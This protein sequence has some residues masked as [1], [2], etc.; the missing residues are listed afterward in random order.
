MLYF[1][2]FILLL[3]NVGFWS[4]TF[5]ALPGNWLIVIS[6]WGFELWRPETVF[7]TT[8][9]VFITVLA[10]IGELIEFIGGMGGAKKAGAGL[11]GTLGALLGAILGAILGTILLPI[12]FAGTFAGACIGAGIG[13]WCFELTREDI[14]PGHAVKMGVGAGIGVLIGTGSKI[15][16]GAL[17]CVIIAF[18]AFV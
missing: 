13:T 6:A 12:P 14:H 10:L 16:I 18:A 5:F 2:I 1:W 3:F 9:L 11:R 15:I 8:T 4:L 17:I 7:S